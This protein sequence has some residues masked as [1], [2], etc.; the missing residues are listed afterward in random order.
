MFVYVFVFPLTCYVSV[1]LLSDG[2]FFE[3][4]L[5]SVKLHQQFLE[6]VEDWKRPG[7]WGY[8]Q[9]TDQ[10]DMPPAENVAI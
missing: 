6:K 1:K 4:F 8:L 7:G 5:I 9:V 3:D 10:W 2:R